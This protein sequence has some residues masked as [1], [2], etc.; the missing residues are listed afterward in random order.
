ML[1]PKVNEEKAKEGG[2]VLGNC[3]LTKKLNLSEG[4]CILLRVYHK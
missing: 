1:I 3:T 2:P 4:E